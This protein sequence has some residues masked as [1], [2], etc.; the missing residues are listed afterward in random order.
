M[1]TH[2]FRDRAS[3][4]TFLICSFFMAGLVAGCASSGRGGGNPFDESEG[5]TTI[6]L[7]VENENVSAANIRIYPGGQMVRLGRVNPGRRE[8]Y[9]LPWNPAHAFVVEIEL[10]AG[11]RYR[12]PSV[13]LA[14]GG[15]VELIVARSLRQ[16]RLRY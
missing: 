9:E 10:V 11:A 7:R 4:W 2:T 6:I 14:R 13:P 16:S 12:L 5:G 8:V 3:P 1:I 15:N